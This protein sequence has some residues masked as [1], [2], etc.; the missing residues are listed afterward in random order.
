MSNFIYELSPTF[1]F[2]LL[3]LAFMFRIY[4]RSIS[5]FAIIAMSVVVI[6]LNNS[7]YQDLSSVLI[8]FTLISLLIRASMKPE[9]DSI[10][11]KPFCGVEK[12]NKRRI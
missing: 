12:R 8:F 3:A 1:T 2:G 4:K 10:V 11:Q 7:G 6:N 9:T 5:T